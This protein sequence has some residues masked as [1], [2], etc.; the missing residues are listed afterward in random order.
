MKFSLDKIEQEVPDE[1]LLAAEGYL[2]VEQLLS[3]HEVEKGLWLAVV[4]GREVELKISGR[5]VVSATCECSQ[6]IGEGRC[7]HIVAAG[8]AVRREKPAATPAV[9]R[10]I[11][12]KPQYKKL[13]VA[14]ILDSID[15]ATLGQFV[16]DYAR[17][18]QEFTT[19]LKARFAS[20]V[21]HLDLA[22]KYGSLL[23]TVIKSNQ[24][25]NQTFARPGEKKIHDTL[26]ML[27]EQALRDTESHNYAEVFEILKNISL[28]VTPIL[29]RLTAHRID[30]TLSLEAT[31][32]MLHR[33][34]GMGMPPALRDSLSELLVEVIAQRYF[35][36]PKVEQAVL[37]LLL[38]VTESPEEKEKFLAFIER[39]LDRRCHNRELEAKMYLYYS[40]IV[41]QNASQDEK[42]EAAQKVASQHW[43]LQHALEFAFDWGMSFTV[44]WLTT[45]L[46]QHKAS[47]ATLERMEEILLQVALRENNKP[48]QE[49]LAAHQILRKQ[50]IGLY[51]IYTAAVDQDS[52]K[53]EHLI[54]QLTALPASKARNNLLCDIYESENMGEAL[55]VLIGR[56]GDLSLLHEHAGYLFGYDARKA[57]EL[58]WRFIDHYLSSHI[59]PPA[60][61]RM[62]NF[63]R[64][65]YHIKQQKAGQTLLARIKRQYGDR[66]YLMEE[67]SLFR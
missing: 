14:A 67:L 3:A 22:E 29:P 56:Q 60:S 20:S 40:A 36:H 31:Y 12:Q 62:Y 10:N 37:H 64:Q 45:V 57:T 25:P 38:R 48:E 66:P 18:N 21:Q 32:R 11:P 23:H 61:R 46:L 63:I 44:K 51:K 55:L 4:E 59:G 43:Q 13:T 54:A 8:L 34:C 26:S 24:S 58:A 17:K 1:L 41:A 5:K 42:S 52:R 28:S 16:S 35:H 15:H 47:E 50:D 30:I 2:A 33:L 19:A 27:L 7:M 53:K 39:E 49:R 65:L 6:Y 9:R